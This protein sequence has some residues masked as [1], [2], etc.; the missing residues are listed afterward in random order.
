[1]VFLAPKILFMPV[2]GNVSNF[3]GVSG[4]EDCHLLDKIIKAQ[5]RSFES[6][7]LQ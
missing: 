5:A 6:K 2:G 4:F 7:L 1:M 3:I